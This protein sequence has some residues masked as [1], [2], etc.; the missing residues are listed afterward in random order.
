MRYDPDPLKLAVYQSCKY[1]SS[2]HGFHECVR[3]EMLDGRKQVRQKTPDKSAK[4]CVPVL[5]GLLYKETWINSKN[6]PIKRPF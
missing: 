2:V 1:I 4:S 6:R 3:G 5:H